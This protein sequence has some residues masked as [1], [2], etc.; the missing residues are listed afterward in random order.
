MSDRIEFGL[1]FLI[2]VCLRQR[3]DIGGHP[4]GGLTSANATHRPHESGRPSVPPD[5]VLTAST[6]F[7]SSEGCNEIRLPHI[8]VVLFETGHHASQFRFRLISLTRRHLVTDRFHGVFVVVATALVAGCSTDASSHL[9]VARS[10]GR[11]HQGPFTARLRGAV[12]GP[13]FTSGIGGH[14]SGLSFFPGP[15]TGLPGDVAC[16]GEVWAQA[17]STATPVNGREPS[18]MN[19]LGR[20]SPDHPA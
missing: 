20:S 12:L 10:V 15:L 6:F 13:T 1:S 14:I 8:D 11:C 9:P 7:E 19:S 18:W 16:V 4:L 3:L 2:V 17:P 5:N